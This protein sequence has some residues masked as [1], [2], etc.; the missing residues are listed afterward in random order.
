MA[1]GWPWMAMAIWLVTACK[2]DYHG[3]MMVNHGQSW[4]LYIYIELLVGG[5]WNH[6]IWIDFP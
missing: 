4:L 5:D 6:G 1:D 3:L 2:W